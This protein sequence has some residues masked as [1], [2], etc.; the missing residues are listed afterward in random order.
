V[1]LGAPE[2]TTHSVPKI[3]GQN[4]LSAT[5]LTG[6]WFRRGPPYFGWATFWCDT[7][8]NPVFRGMEDVDVSTRLTTGS[9]S[10]RMCAS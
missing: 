7:R 8:P 6:I 5:Q 10:V 4:G 9:G 3:V 2:K 1:F